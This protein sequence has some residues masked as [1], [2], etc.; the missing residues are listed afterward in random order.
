M[1][2]VCTGGQPDPSTCLSK[3][4]SPLPK[5]YTV[6]INLCIGSDKVTQTILDHD[7]KKPAC[8]YL[9]ILFLET[10][11]DKQSK[12]S[13]QCVE[14]HWRTL[15]FVQVLNCNTLYLQVFAVFHTNYL[16]LD[17]F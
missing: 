3:A 13:D 16:A 14:L 12:E 11:W 15:R 1:F 2:K 17:Y 9:F 4:Q 5:A 10:I 8:I 7:R 6:R